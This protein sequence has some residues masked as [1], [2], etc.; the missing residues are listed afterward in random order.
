ML[1]AGGDGVLDLSLALHTSPSLL[2]GGLGNVGGAGGGKL[3]LPLLLDRG[4]DGSFTF[5]LDTSPG[6]SLASGSGF[7]DLAS[8][9][10]PSEVS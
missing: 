1:L 10:D 7:G 8:L 4:A 3:S 5:S 6:G 9:L 2:L